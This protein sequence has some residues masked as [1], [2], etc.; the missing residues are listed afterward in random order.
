MKQIKASLFFNILSYTYGNINF[1]VLRNF[2]FN[3]YNVRVYKLRLAEVINL[4]FNL[5]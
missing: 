3:N 1:C 4:L 5:H 2:E